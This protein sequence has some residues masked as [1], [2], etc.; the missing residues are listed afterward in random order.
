MALELQTISTAEPADSA[1]RSQTR[2]T[3]GISVLKG[4]ERLGVVDRMFFTEQLSLL[5]ETGNSLTQALGILKGQTKKVA[6]Q[7]VIESLIDDVSGGKTFAQSLAAHPALFGVTYVNL[8]D[9]S[10]RAGF[11]HTIMAELLEMDE[12]RERLASTVK[13]SLSYPIFLLGF[14]LLVVV[15]ML[16]VVFP[17]FA[18]MFAALGDDL[19]LS[20]RLLMGFSQALIDYWPLFLAGLAGLGFLI[21]RTLATEAGRD[22]LDRSK[23]R[24]PVLGGV[25]AELYLVQS[26][27]ALALSLGNGVSVMD[28]LAS[29]RD[30]VN[31]QYYRKFIG[32][33]EQ[34]VQEGRG[35]ATG[36]RNE[37]F[38]PDLVQQ[39]IS[40]GEESGNLPRVLHRIVE[41]YERQLEKR[42]Q[43]LAKTA[44]PLMLLV[45]GVVVGFLVSSLILP[46]FMMSRAV[47]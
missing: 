2:S 39:M 5:L 45:M 25:F 40:T 14:S 13:S 7:R 11:L 44:E 32:R 22:W 27:R 29:C 33:L 47:G 28:G 9:A 19:P 36:V 6:L 15:F 34:S 8:I 30:V 38:I 43:T 31:N 20:T 21:I 23:L 37:S 4:R 16:V 41:Y 26:M 35:I 18:D 10:E 1:R 42:L 24:L 12:R 46:I 17:K 3:K